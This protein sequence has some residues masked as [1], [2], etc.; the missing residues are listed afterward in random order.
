MYRVTSGSSF[1]LAYLDDQRLAP[2]AVSALPAWLWS[3][4]P[5]RILWANPT[6]AAIFGTSTS[7]AVSA[8]VFDGGQPAAAQI[9]E[10]AARLPDDGSPRI[11]H[12]RGFG[13]GVESA[14]ACECSRIVLAD[15]T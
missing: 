10:L 8:R 14:L 1:G 15:Q 3:L 6:G 7:A 4:D 12:L 11:E 2:L 13:G 5:T 9:V